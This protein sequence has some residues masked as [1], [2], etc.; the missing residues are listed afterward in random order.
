MLLTYF[1]L[2]YNNV[3]TTVIHFKSMFDAHLL[4][5]SHYLKGPTHGIGCLE[6]VC[7]D[8]PSLGN[9]TSGTTILFN[10]ILS[11]YRTY[12]FLSISG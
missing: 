7:F 5:T 2:I 12:K 11:L 6:M 1:E 3:L 10:S 8:S 4:I 9:D